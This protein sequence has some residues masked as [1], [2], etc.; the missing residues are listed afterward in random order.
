[1]K[2]DDIRVKL[3]EI[4]N[5][6]NDISDLCDDIDATPCEIPEEPEEPEEPTLPTAV[7]CLAGTNPNWTSSNMYSDELNETAWINARNGFKVTM[8]T[9]PSGS[10]MLLGDS[11]L[12]NLYEEEISP[13]A[14]NFGISGESS[15]QLLY[16]L[17]ENDSN[18]QPNLI[19]RAG[20]VV[21]LTGIN[22]GSDSRNGSQSNA[23]ITVTQIYDKISGWLT[24]KVVIVKLVKLNTSVFSTPSNTAFVDYVNNW[25][26]TEFGGR[27]G[28]AIVD[29]NPTVAPSGTLLSQYSTDGQHLNTAA[30]RAVLQ[31]AI[32]DAL[33]NLNVIGE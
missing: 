27:S 3:A 18:G 17:N 13:Y 24:G 8:S 15:R 28:F 7:D 4:N 31:N 14:L 12:A 2:T 20:A 1:M 5:R 11:M 16:R 22:D 26:T 10:I 9:A 33:E 32:K 30:G 25:I 19:H 21:L 29:V 6:L 23:A